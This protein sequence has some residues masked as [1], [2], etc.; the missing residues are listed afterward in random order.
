MYCR[1]EDR[2]AGQALELVGFCRRIEARTPQELA[3]ALA[4]VEAAWRAGHWV[5]LMLDFELGEWLLPE[6]LDGAAGGPCGNTGEPGRSA[7]GRAAQRCSET[8]AGLQAHGCGCAGEAADA[9]RAH[10]PAEPVPA[11]ATDG[12]GKAA[13]ARQRP[14]LRA[15]VFDGAV[16]GQPWPTPADAG[17]R[18]LDLKPRTAHDEYLK[19]VEVIRAGIGR[20]EFYQVNYTQP[21]DLRVQGDPRELYARIA[22]A[23]PI[24]H[25]AYIEDGTQ[26]ILSFSPELFVARQGATLTARPMKGTAPRDADP[27]R[28]EALGR[29][30][31]ASAKNRAENLMIVDLLRN[32]LGRLAEPGSVKVDELFTLERYPSVWTMTS[33]IRAQAPHA[34]LGDILTALFPCGSVTGAPKIAAMRHIRRAENAPRGLYCGSIGWLAPDGDFSL[35]VAIRTLVLDADGNG[36]YGA[37]GGI[38]HDSDAESEWQECLWKARILAS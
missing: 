23:N 28:D 20:G 4:A 38:V 12:D 25:A 22:A 7:I 32:D 26:T 21:M 29:E 35:N 2:L 17:S 36:I 18:I 37:G 27:Q 19:Q 24:A 11:A 34:T 15:L 16:K 5:A 13:P 33:T 6:V 8:G 3:G 10:A 30:L 1:F 31:H 9:A 14:R